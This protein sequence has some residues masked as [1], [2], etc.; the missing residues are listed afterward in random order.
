MEPLNATIRFDG[1]AAEAWV[2]S[3]FQTF[4]QMAIAEVLGLKPEQVTF[5]TEFAGGGFGRRAVPDCHIPRE[6]AAIAKHLTLFPSSA[7][8]LDRL[9]M[10]QLAAAQARLAVFVSNDTGPLHIAAAVGAPVVVLLD[11][12]AP[13]TYLPP[14]ESKRVA[15]SDLVSDITVGEVYELTR[16]LLAAG[17]T[18][19]LFA[20]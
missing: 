11:Q 15:R 14:T 20:E 10:R 5:H 9:S 12:R 17:R 19:A 8:I 3:Q 16:E 7:I 1:D 13:V 18:A 6:A 2:P 4:D